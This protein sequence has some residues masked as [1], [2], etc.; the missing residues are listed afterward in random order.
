[1][2]GI[3]IFIL[4]DA[5]GWELIRERPFLAEY[6]RTSS[7]YARCWASVRASSPRF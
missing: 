6:L 4:I 3:R 5:M 1:M 7:R 2:S